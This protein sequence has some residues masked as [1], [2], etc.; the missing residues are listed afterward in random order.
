MPDLKLVVP[1]R[2]DYVR[3]L[4]AV[5]SSLAA[6][7]EFTYDR[8]EDL[9]LAVSEACATLLA[10]PWEARTLVLRVYASGRSVTAVVCSDAEPAPASW[11]P[12]QVERT[13]AWRVLSGLADR[14]AFEIGEEGPA[15]RLEIAGGVR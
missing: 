6:R 14:A 5:A 10:Q 12:T 4:R 7:L 1:A 3:L 13:L 9:R 11:P 15:V 8:I 2:P